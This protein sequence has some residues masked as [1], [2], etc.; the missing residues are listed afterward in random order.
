MKGMTGKGTSELNKIEMADML[1][2]LSVDTGVPLPN[3]EDAGFIM[4]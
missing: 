3:P 2:R 1:D 4:N